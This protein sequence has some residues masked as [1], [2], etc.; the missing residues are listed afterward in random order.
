M[1]VTDEYIQL[2]TDDVPPTV[3]DSA[4]P[5]Y[6]TPPSASGQF[7]YANPFMTLRSRMNEALGAAGVVTPAWTEW[8]GRAQ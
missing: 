2:T 5:S 4:M 1:D 8:Q 3:E 6:M 7:I